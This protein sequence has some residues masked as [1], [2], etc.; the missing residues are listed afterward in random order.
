MTLTDFTISKAKPREK[1]YKLS[2]EKGLFLLISPPGRTSK[3]VVSR[4]WRIKYRFSG[5]EKLLALGSYPAVSLAE[6]RKR[7]ETARELLARGIDPAVERKAE[8]HARQLRAENT[9]ETIAR[10]FIAK[11]ANR[12]SNDYAGYV[13]RRLDVNIFPDIGQRPIAEID[14]PELLQVVRKIESRGAHEMAHRILQLSGLVFRYGVATGKCARNP[15]TDLRGAL[16]PHKPKRMA[17]VEPGDLPELLRRI[18]AYDSS[19]FGGDRQTRLAL[20]LLAMTFVRTNELR[21]A[22]WPEFDLDNAIWTIPPERAK[23]HDAYLVPLSHQSLQILADLKQLNRDQR[24]AFPG[25]GLKG[26]MSE[27]TILYALY[28]LGYR[29][30]MTGHGFRA[31]ASTVLNEH[32]FNEDWIERQLDHRHRNNVRDAY[33]R[34]KYLPQRRKMMQ[35]YADHLDELRRRS[36]V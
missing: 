29:S 26:V 15:A 32:G 27:N 25:E 10:E 22:E 16:T 19:E 2:D 17:A 20:Q 23:M 35:W 8:K 13:L 4:L 31:V 1:P 21:K 9:F 33:N 36:A 14:P 7:R 12:W 18:E 11:Q 24:F 5:K 30:R 34:A 3:S 28:R 6:A